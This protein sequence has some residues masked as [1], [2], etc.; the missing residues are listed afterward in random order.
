MVENETTFSNLK[1]DC[2]LQL[3]H[4]KRAKSTTCWGKRGE[5]V[6]EQSFS[7]DRINIKDE[8]LF[9]FV[10]PFREVKFRSGDWFIEMRANKFPVTAGLFK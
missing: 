1:S 9:S 2:D 5:T 8:R 4:F 7:K 3:V 6:K 10:F